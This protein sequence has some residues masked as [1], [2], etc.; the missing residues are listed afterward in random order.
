MSAAV[1]PAD[2]QMAL[3]PFNM[4][5]LLSCGVEGVLCRQNAP[6]STSNS[7]KSVKVPPTSTPKRY[8]IG[9]F[10]L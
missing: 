1:I 10:S 2:S 5:S 8:P 6:V 3:T 9:F 4:P 7:S